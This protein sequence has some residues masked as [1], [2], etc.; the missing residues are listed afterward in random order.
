MTD[1]TKQAIAAA[2]LESRDSLLTSD[3]KAQCILA[4]AVVSTLSSEMFNKLITDVVLTVA[5]ASEECDDVNELCEHIHKSINDLESVR[6]LGGY[7][8]LTGGLL[9]QLANYVKDEVL[10]INDEKQTVRNN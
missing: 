1:K 6:M 4:A 9:E 7:L 3:S 5:K 10:S 2:I 8:D